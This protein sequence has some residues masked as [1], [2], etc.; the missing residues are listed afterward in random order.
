MLLKQEG[1]VLL[2]LVIEITGICIFLNGFFPLKSSRS[3]LSKWGD[4]PLEPLLQMGEKN[5]S[6]KMEKHLPTI[7][8]RT[9]L[10]LIDALRADFV[11]PEYAEGDDGFSRMEFL[12][13]LIDSRQTYSYISR[14]HPPTVTM[15]RIKVGY[16]AL[17]S[18]EVY[19]Y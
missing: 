15:P 8:G 16:S 2:C 13:S 17:F 5:S 9:V 10:I 18:L 11:L 14:A 7:F 19:T 4:F 12:R 6:N 3:G 1:L